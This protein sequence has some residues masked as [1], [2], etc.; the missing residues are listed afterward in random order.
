[1]KVN[2][3]SA[4]N[5]FEDFSRSRK[6]LSGLLC[7]NLVVCVMI[8]ES[9]KDSP[10]FTLYLAELSASSVDKLSKQSVIEKV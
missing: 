4:L 5:S 1:M 6:L 2:K 8:S 3:K 10:D 7:F 9:W